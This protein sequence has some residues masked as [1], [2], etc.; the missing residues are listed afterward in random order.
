MIERL[1]IDNCGH[2]PHREQSQLTQQAII[3][4]LKDTP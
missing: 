2:S 4:F 1:T 3:Q